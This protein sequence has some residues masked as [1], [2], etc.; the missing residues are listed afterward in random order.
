MPGGI[1]YG[2][3]RTG[4][5]YAIKYVHDMIPNEFGENFPVF[6][7]E[8]AYH[9]TNVSDNTFYQELLTDLNH[10]FYKQGRAP[11]KLKRLREYLSEQID[12]SGHWQ[13]VLIF[14]DA[15][16]L[17]AY[18][19]EWLMDIYNYLDKIQIKP[20]FLFVGQPELGFLRNSFQGTNKNQIIGRFMVC[21]QYFHGLTN[22][23]D[24]STCLKV[25]DGTEFSGDSYTRD[26]YKNAWDQ[27][28]RIEQYSQLIWD[29]FSKLRVKFSMSEDFE[30]PMQFFC[31]VI[32]NLFKKYS[33]PETT[34]PII[35]EKMI[36]KLIKDS[37]YIE[38]E[39]NLNSNFEN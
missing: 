14:D 38:A 30:I 19:Y 23:D 4:K 29:S 39:F 21:E 18:Q 17:Y 37:R 27:G 28:W 10:A 32:E 11:D 33:D 3:Q 5:T 35:N 20:T 1:L 13:A 2:F 7:F 36:I 26:F 22:P 16:R 34:E 9:K 24:I 31:S 15:H 8:C 25:Y 6:I 12:N